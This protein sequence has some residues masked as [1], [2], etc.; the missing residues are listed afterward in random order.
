V[1]PEAAEDAEAEVPEAADDGEAEELLEFPAEPLPQP[2]NSDVAANDKPRQ[3]ANN[4]FFIY[5]YHL[6]FN[7]DF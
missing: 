1:S 4:L 2:A 7:I 5:V 6:S 3:S